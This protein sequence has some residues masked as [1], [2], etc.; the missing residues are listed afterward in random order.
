M[1]LAHLKTKQN[2]LFICTEENSMVVLT[3]NG[4]CSS[5]SLWGWV[6]VR[7]LGGSEMGVRR[8]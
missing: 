3:G 2:I 4:P 1:T 7:R 8:E 6:G 5:T